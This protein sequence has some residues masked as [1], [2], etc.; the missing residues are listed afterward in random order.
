MSQLLGLMS[1]ISEELG[2]R[3]AA[4]SS[5]AMPPS[6]PARLLRRL[7]QGEEAAHATVDL[8]VVEQPSEEPLQAKLATLSR[9]LRVV[10]QGWALRAPPPPAATMATTESSLQTPSLPSRSCN[11]AAVASS[12]APCD[13]TVP[14]EAPPSRCRGCGVPHAQSDAGRH[15]LERS[16]AVPH[17]SPSVPPP[18]AP[19]S[20][21]S[22]PPPPPPP[23]P[24][25]LPPALMPPPI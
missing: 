3:D 22:V 21:A 14:A 23:L 17:A 9:Y 1:D 11:G 2:S 8:Q 6:P 18:V 25:P 24:P 15:A 13:G 12:V 7:S 20:A 16:G 19:S 5:A 10:Q 4:A